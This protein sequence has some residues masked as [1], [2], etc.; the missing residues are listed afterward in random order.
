MIKPQFISCILTFI[1]Q[2]TSEK[3]HPLKTNSVCINIQFG[4]Q[5]GK[6]YLATVRSFR[7]QKLAPK[8]KKTQMREIGPTLNDFASHLRVG[9]GTG[10]DLRVFSALSVSPRTGSF[11]TLEAGGIKKR[12]VEKT[13][14]AN[15]GDLPTCLTNLTASSSQGRSNNLFQNK[16]QLSHHWS[17]GSNFLNTFLCLVGLREQRIYT[18]YIHR[19]PNNL[20]LNE[21]NE[22]SAS[23]SINKYI[24]E[25][26]DWINCSKWSIKDCILFIF[27]ISFDG[28]KVCKSNK[29][30]QITCP[31]VGMK[32]VIA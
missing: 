3:I 13:I 24:F 1:T 2:R 10:V 30:Y 22:K 9:T 4:R 20:N 23:Q 29:V 12:D 5:K 7:R 25:N 14:F 18:I 31:I 27:K 8:R 6:Y 26:Y 17:L 15:Y 28:L 21:Y 16:N 11:R 32:S 19:M